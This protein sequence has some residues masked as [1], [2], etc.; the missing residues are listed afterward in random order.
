L[1][2]T[3]TLCRPYSRCDSNEAAGIKLT[4]RT[5]LLTSLVLLLLV[6][7]LLSSVPAAAEDGPMG[8]TGATGSTGPTGP[9]REI[10]PVGP[11]GSLGPEVPVVA[12]AIAQPAN[13]LPGID[14][15]HHQGAIDWVQVAASGQRFAIAKATEGR[16]FVDPNYATN[17]AGALANGI[18]FGAYHFARPDDGTND[19]VIE[20]DHFVDVAQLGPGNLIPVLDIE[21]TGGLTQAQVTTWILTWLGRVTERLGVRPMVYTSPSGWENRTG[22]T[23]AVADAGYTVLWVAHW[24]VSEPRLPANDW[25]GNGWTFWQYHNCGSV[26]GISGCVDVDWYDGT[27]FDPVLIPSPD[28]VPPTVAFAVPP[29]GDG[30]IVASF[31][32]VVHQVTTDNT[33][34]WTP[35]S[36]TYPAVQLSCL[37]RRAVQ[38]DCMTGNVRTVWIDPVDPLI[39]GES[40]EAVVNPAIVPLA[41]VD[42]AGNPTPTTSA[43]FAPP[44]AVEQD[45]PAVIYGWR[46]A[47]NAGASGGTYAVE[48]R[49]GASMSFEFEGDAVSWITATGPAQGVAAVSID[50]ARVGIFDQFSRR[51]AFGVL[52]TFTG[53][54]EGPH[55]ILV[56]VLGRASASA[57]DTRVVVD[58]FQA[59]GVRVQESA[60]E[61]SWASASLPQASA[62]DVVASDLAGASLLLS[63]RGTGIEWT[64]L[65]DRD[66]GRAA[67]YVD[68]VLVREVDNFATAPLFGVTRSV[69]GLVEGV[70]TLAVVVL[71]ESRTRATGTLV[72]IDRLA[73]I[74]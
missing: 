18:A 52:R 51:T 35:Q 48:R 34:V 22:D 53:L 74:P 49:A 66:Q 16:T 29:G 36:G 72:T 40:Y 60:G 11:L 20:A 8:S 69:I 37:S 56:R 17:K 10:G 5:R 54:G 44:T 31:S 1:R 45:N 14:V 30:P 55:R 68:G 33:F 38:V 58:G 27:S 64:T 63:F 61:A 28:S 12:P 47:T 42:R 3:V 71:G 39:P 6:P 2:G 13:S 23:T 62:G 21:R 59:G 32:E 9:T 25:N 65:R 43:P 50:G 67:I 70:H 7:A 73:T 4:T 24:G 41:V 46:T 26:A 19:A 15:S 57:K